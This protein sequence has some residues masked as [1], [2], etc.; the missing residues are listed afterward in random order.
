M[1]QNF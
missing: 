1:G